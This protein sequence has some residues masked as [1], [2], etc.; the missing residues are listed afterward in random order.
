FVP[1]SDSPA[2]IHGSSPKYTGSSAMAGFRSQRALAVACAGLAFGFMAPAARRDSY[3]SGNRITLLINFAPG[4]S[5]DVQGRLFAKYLAKHLAPKAGAAPP[6]VI[7][8]N[9]EGGGGV[10][11]VNYLGEIAPKDGTTIGY[12]SG[13]AWQSAM[14]PK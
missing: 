4:G 8:Q 9:M 11:G 3:F 1:F 12:S 14:D 5:T 10:T 7:I 13:T 2:T 6:S